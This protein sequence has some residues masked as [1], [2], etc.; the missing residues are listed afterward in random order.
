M[1]VLNRLS[2]LFLSDNEPS[3]NV[4]QLSFRIIVAAARIWSLRYLELLL[5]SLLEY[6][7]DK[8]TTGNKKIISTVVAVVE[9]PCSLTVPVNLMSLFFEFQIQFRK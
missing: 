9:F 1:R 2:F 3:V 8:R 4:V 7:R 5:L 6:L